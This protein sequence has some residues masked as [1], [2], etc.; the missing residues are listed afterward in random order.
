MGWELSLISRPAVQE[1]KR[2]NEKKEPMLQTNDRIDRIAYKTKT[3]FNI[4]RNFKWKI[5]WNLNSIEQYIL[6]G[7]DIWDALS[8]YFVVLT[9][10]MLKSST[11]SAHTNYSPYSQ[12]VVSPRHN[13]INWYFFL[14]VVI[15]CAKKYDQKS[16]N[17]YFF[18]RKF[19]I[20]LKQYIAKSFLDKP[21]SRWGKKVR[22]LWVCP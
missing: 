8:I 3:D 18:W 5:M 11:E 16:F 2:W 15:V 6:S 1:N 22:V 14:Y 12:F 21:M 9:A 4:C 13:F 17:H 10:A 20:S 7:L 19:F